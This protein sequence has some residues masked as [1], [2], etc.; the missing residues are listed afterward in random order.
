MADTTV[1]DI[2]GVFTQADIER[3]DKIKNDAANNAKLKNQAMDQ[4]AFMK[5]LAAQL[6]HQDPLSPMKD[7]EFIGQMA[8]FNSLNAMNNL[9]ELTEENSQT[10]RDM[11]A[12]MAAMGVGID[13]LV[14]KLAPEKE[15]ETTT[16][17]DGTKTT[18][19]T[20]ID[21]TVTT[22]VTKPDGTVTTT[23]TDSN[24]KQLLDV[25]NETLE[26]MKKM[27]SEMAK[28]TEAMKAY[29]ND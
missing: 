28:L 16:A 10:D 25:S 11:A 22:T 21:G 13:K 20:A 23:T 6:K 19:V 14:A 27:T 5:I 24:S 8:Q 4:D 17:D 15:E 12:I 29:A 18:T 9:V 1:K 7:Q 3:L 26:E 2:R